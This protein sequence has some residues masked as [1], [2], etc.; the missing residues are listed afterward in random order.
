MGCPIENVFHKI[1]DFTIEGS[2]ALNEYW[3]KIDLN[4]IE[5][6][7]IFKLIVFVPIVDTN[8]MTIH[9]NMRNEVVFE[10]QLSSGE[11]VMLSKKLYRLVSINV[12]AID[13]FDAMKIAQQVLNGINLQLLKAIAKKVEEVP[14]EKV[15]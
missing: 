8:N 12:E 4:D 3:W 10:Q 15:A 1:N 7:Y 13:F 2:F 9:P 11:L 5:K 6:Q 14:E